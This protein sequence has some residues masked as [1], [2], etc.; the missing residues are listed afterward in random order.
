MQSEIGRPE[1]RDRVL[2]DIEMA[3][4]KEEKLLPKRYRPGD[5]NRF[6]PLARGILEHLELCG[7]RF[8]RKPP[9]PKHSTSDPR[10]GA[11]TGE[12]GN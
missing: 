1:P 11:G 5:H 3:L 8:F 6:R 4:Q 12:D 2:F 10:G 7:L 9:A